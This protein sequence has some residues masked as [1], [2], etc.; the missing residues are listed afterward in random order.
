MKVQGVYAAVLVP[1]NDDGTVDERGF[2]NI[3]EFLVTSNLPRVVVNGATGEYCATSPRE[4]AR[5]LEICRETLPTGADLFAGIGSA[6]LPGCLELGRVAIDGGAQT[7]LL[8]MPHFFPY[9]QDDLE[10]F[11]AAAATQLD[12]PILLYNLPRF[13]TPIEL[14]TVRRLLDRSPNIV[15]I[16]DSSGSLTILRGLAGT[17]ACRVLGD[18]SA[19]VSAVAEGACDA[20]ISG[21]AG[22]APELTS[23]LFHHRDSPR[24]AEAGQL[25]TRLIEQLGKFP[26]PW[27]LKLIAECRGLGP[28]RFLQPASPARAA[29]ADAFRTWFPG[30]WSEVEAVVRTA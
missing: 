14:G 13:T 15:G 25:L 19:L 5:L 17:R 10:A 9:S 4:L 1:R 7:L 29:A 16:K 18:D 30:W 23:F 12:V 8:P 22:V 28:A 6:E 21:V 27:G 24:Y 20:V 11:C 3:L 26:I 2:R